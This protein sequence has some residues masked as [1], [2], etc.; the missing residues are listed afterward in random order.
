[1]VAAN[2]AIAP[3]AQLVSCK[4]L[5]RSMRAESHPILGLDS[6]LDRYRRCFQRRGFPS[7]F[8][9]VCTARRLGLGDCLALTMVFPRNFGRIGYCDCYLDVSWA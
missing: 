3:T 1:M 8:S 4:S 9:S 2:G 7:R 6:N 5:L